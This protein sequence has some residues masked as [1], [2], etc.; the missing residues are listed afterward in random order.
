MF[1]GLYLHFAIEFI[2]FKVGCSGAKALETRELR[3]Q[4][5]QDKEDAR[6]NKLKDFREQTGKCHDTDKI[7]CQ[8]FYG[9]A[10]RNR[11]T[12]QMRELGGLEEGESQCTVL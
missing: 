6:Q 5:E 1:D 9:C 11:L 3:L 8:D 10:C 2:W 4:E 7:K 12:E